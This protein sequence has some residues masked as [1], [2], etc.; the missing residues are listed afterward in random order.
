MSLF[1]IRRVHAKAECFMTGKEGPALEFSRGD[2]T[3][4]VVVAIKEFE[5]LIRLEMK[6][7]ENAPQKKGPSV[8][9]NDS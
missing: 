8:T 3:E 2:E 7:K 6:K 4:T 9:S 1:T 5:K